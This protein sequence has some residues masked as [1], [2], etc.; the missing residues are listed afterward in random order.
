MQSINAHV[1]CDGCRYDL[2]RLSDDRQCPECGHPI[3]DSLRIWQAR[4]TRN[5]SLLAF[6]CLVLLVLIS[7]GVFLAVSDVFVVHPVRNCHPI[8]SRETSI[9]IAIQLYLI[10]TKLDRPP[11]GF[12]MCVLL[13]GPNE[14][15][16]P[17]GPYL[18]SA[19]DLLSVTDEPYTLVYDAQSEMLDL[20]T[21][22]SETQT[23]SP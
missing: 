21:S 1:E 5:G 15:G 14:G 23:R 19:R 4:T 18:Q 11:S 7:C 13:L 8:R 12:E 9:L 10:D 16:G 20:V 22:S 17:N 2:Y 3:D 6:H